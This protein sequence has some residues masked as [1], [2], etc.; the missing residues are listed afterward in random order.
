MIE[1]VTIDLVHYR[2]NVDKIIDFITKTDI[3]LRRMATT[4][5]REVENG[6][7]YRQEIL[8]KIRVSGE[9]DLL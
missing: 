6:L 7:K 2:S 1:N 4:R 5:C 3:N 8:L 9:I